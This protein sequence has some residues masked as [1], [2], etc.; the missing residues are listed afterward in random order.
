MPYCPKCD[1]EFVD[2]V[3]VCSDCG[4]PL[5]ASKEEADRMA[6]EAARLERERLEAEAGELGDDTSGSGEGFG[7]NSGEAARPARVRPKTYVKKSQKYED[8]KSSVSA[9]LLVGLILGVFAVLCWTGILNMPMAGVS[10]YL[11]QG[12]ITFM[13]VGCFLVAFSTNR[14]AQAVFSQIEG[15]ERETAEIIQW[16]LDS[17]R[18]DDLDSR[19]HNE[20]PDLTDEELS[21]KRFEL[22]Q[23]LLV[24]GKD[25]PD[26]AYVDALCEEIYGKMFEE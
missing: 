14:S 17:Y 3:T 22:I 23:D 10:K 15:E 16:F 21:L 19:L 20:F 5:V 11:I 8:M 6:A 12:V 1:M 24:T 4:G 9:F 25:L 13:A 26:Q 2:G 7:G 18:K